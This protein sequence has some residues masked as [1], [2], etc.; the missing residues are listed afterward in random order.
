MYGVSISTISAARTGTYHQT[1]E[2][3]PR[4]ASLYR[5]TPKLTPHQVT[6]I[7]HDRLLSDSALAQ[8]HNV[9]PHTIKAI[10]KG[11]LW[12]RLHPN[13]PLPPKRITPREAARIILDHLPYDTYLHALTKH[14]PPPDSLKAAFEGLLKLPATE[15]SA[16]LKLVPKPRQYLQQRSELP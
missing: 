15:L 16:L 10:R 14:R 7:L 2:T 11:R 4:P 8:A 5:G 13:N 12:R 3:P 1:A 6:S 9:S